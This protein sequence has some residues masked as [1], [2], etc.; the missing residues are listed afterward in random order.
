MGAIRKGKAGTSH[1][2]RK[3]MTPKP[4][5]FG[6]L[7]M[8]ISANNVNRFAEAAGERKDRRLG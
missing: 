1:L 4:V 3:V 8:G 5:S 2:Q 6:P 7:R